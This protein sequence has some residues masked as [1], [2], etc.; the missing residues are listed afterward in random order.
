MVAELRIIQ[1]FKPRSQKTNVW[2]NADPIPRV[3][4]FYHLILYS[5]TRPYFAPKS[6]DKCASYFDV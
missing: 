2:V 4:E 6:I 3:G 5:I 1:C